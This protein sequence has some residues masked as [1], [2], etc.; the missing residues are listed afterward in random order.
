MDLAQ[1]ISVE[2]A[3]TPSGYAVSYADEWYTWAQLG[4]F[5]DRFDELVGPIGIDTGLRVA[6][7]LRNQPWHFASIAAT[8]SLRHT[9][10]TLNPSIGDEAMAAEIHRVRPHVVVA[11][12]EDWARPGIREAASDVAGVVPIE[13]PAGRT[14]APAR[15]DLRAR[16]PTIEP[17]APAPEVAVE[18]QTSGTTGAPKRVPLSYADLG[19]SLADVRRHH[20]DGPRRGSDSK[21][22]GIGILCNPPVHMSGMYGSIRA[23][24]SGRTV[25]LLD[26]FTVDAWKS[27]MVK[28][29]PKVANLVP[30]AIRMVL[31]A[32]VDP[33]VL[34]SVRVMTTGSAPMPAELAIEFEDTYATPVLVSYGATEFAGGIAGWT[35]RD[36]MKFG[37]AKRGS[38]GAPHPGTELRVV[39]PATGE[40]VPCGDTGVLEVRSTQLMDS[41]SWVRTTDLA[42]LDEDGYLWIKGR[43][44]GVI[45]RGGFKIWP[46]EVQRVLEAHPSVREASVFGIDDPRLGQVPIAVVERSWRAAEADPDELREHCRK[47]LAPYQVPARVVVLDALPRTPSLKVAQA[48]LRDLIETD[49]EATT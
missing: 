37:K 27:A 46:A 41:Q 33:D 14:P 2:L 31:D 7:L 8:L 34:S 25:V 1:Q 32:K 4:E 18:M 49:A 17:A 16:T 21:I 26:R 24:S 19:R 39:D 15:V 47:S 12:A 45:I 13:L 3:A 44:D 35:Y 20:G 5:R 9:I 38:V 22:R 40:A 6:I 28:H 42:T 48:Q 36:Y 43:A 30:A 10:V 23:L 29:R 11:S